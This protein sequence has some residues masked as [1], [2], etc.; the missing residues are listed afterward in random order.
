[1]RWQNGSDD[2]SR[3]WWMRWGCVTILIAGNST[4]CQ[5]I[6]IKVRRTPTPSGGKRVAMRWNW[7]LLLWAVAESV[8]PGASAHELWL[9]SR[10]DAGVI[11]L[12]FGDG[13]DMS[14]AERVAEIAN[15]KVWAGDKPLIVK[16]LPDGLEA[17]LPPGGSTV[18]SAFADRGIVAHAGQSSL[19]YLAAYAQTR[20]MESELVAWPGPWRRSSATPLIFARQ[21]AARHSCDPEGTTCRRRDR[22]GFSWA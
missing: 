3:V 22:Q 16:Q 17:Q 8:S 12:T 14:A 21:W 9:H 1:M 10:T 6:I 11:R 2:A 19:I 13:P 20:A 4:I 18:I 5:F 7:M 15:T